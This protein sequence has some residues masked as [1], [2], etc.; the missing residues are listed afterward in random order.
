[1]G[2]QK[3]FLRAFGAYMKTCKSQEKIAKIPE[4]V[5]KIDLNIPVVA[6]FFGRLGML[7]QGCQ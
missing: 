1:M 4:K 6:L 3:I 5:R 2:I 7:L